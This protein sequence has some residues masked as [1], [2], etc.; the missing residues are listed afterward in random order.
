[1]PKGNKTSY[2]DKYKRD[3]AHVRNE[4]NR[5]SRGTTPS[6]TRRREQNRRTMWGELYEI[7]D[8]E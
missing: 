6:E 5:E 2:T 1:M 8:G 7:Y 3:T 4:N